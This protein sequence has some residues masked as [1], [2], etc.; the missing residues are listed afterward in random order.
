MILSRH[1][2]TSSPIQQNRTD[3][4][5]VMGAF[6]DIVGI[7]A[8]ICYIISK[9]GIRHGYFVITDTGNGTHGENWSGSPLEP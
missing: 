1:D 2:V 4:R 7:Y 8:E 3:Q 9:R 6:A 5:Y